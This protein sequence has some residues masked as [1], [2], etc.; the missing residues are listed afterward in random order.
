MSR[1]ARTILT[2]AL[3]TALLAAPALASDASDAWK[4]AKELKDAVKKG[5]DENAKAEAQKAFE[6]FCRKKVEVLS[7]SKS[8]LSKLDL[9]YLGL[10]QGWAGDKKGAVDT[11]RAAVEKKEE[12]KYGANV[13]AGL[14]QAL[15]ENDEVDGAAIEAGKMRELYAEARETKTTVTNVGM[16]YRRALQHEKAAVW[17]QTALD[18]NEYAVI[19]PL[20]NSLLLAG[21]KSEAV[22]AAKG[23]AEK[24]P[25]PM[26]D[27]MNTLAAIT[28][29][30]GE[31]VSD[32]LKFDAYVPSGEPDLKDKVVVLGFWNVSARTLK[33]TLG[34][35][36]RVRKN[37]GDDVVVL[38][39]T[40]YYKKDPDTGKI[41]DSLTPD[42]ERGV[43]QR[44]QDEMGWRGWM[45][46]CKDEQATR[47]WGLSGLPF[48]V[49]VSKDRKLLFAHTMSWIDDTD[50]KVLDKILQ[51]ATG[52][53]GR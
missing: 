37:Y 13:H 9:M 50:Q 28:E 21:K 19:K 45:A 32:M 4:Q 7:S 24:G 22:A 3:S 1:L 30:F 26:K 17:L 41:D 33:W 25:P 23:V 11:M 14:V 38:A 2:L 47:D 8:S 29:K 6:D 40:T 48:F 31:D 5:A 20:V 10:L 42:R 46:Y 49:V 16:A 36:D 15:I 27:D 35:L 34:L 43:G 53:T 18:M 44:V 52:S 12:T 51:Q 39:A